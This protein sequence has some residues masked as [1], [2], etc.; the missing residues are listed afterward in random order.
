MLDILETEG[1]NIGQHNNTINRYKRTCLSIVLL[2][3]CGPHTSIS[4][5]SGFYRQPE[6]RRIDPNPD[7]RPTLPRAA[8]TP[9][10]LCMYTLYRHARERSTD[11]SPQLCIHSAYTAVCCHIHGTDCSPAIVNTLRSAAIAM[12]PAR[13]RYVQQCHLCPQTYR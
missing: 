6:T 13:D 2:L 11:C 7:R 12:P 9:P 3:C 8:S 5:L 10:M 4:I 1:P